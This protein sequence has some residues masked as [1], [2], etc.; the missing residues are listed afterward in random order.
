MQFEWD[1]RKRGAV[2]AKHG[3]DFRRAVQVFDDP[4]F[5]YPSSRQDEERWVMVG[6]V[7][8]R[9][10]ADRASG[11]DPRDLHEESEE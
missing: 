5:T 7:H 8:G 1:E 11:R 2:F 4:S 9:G 3:L 10:R 6:T